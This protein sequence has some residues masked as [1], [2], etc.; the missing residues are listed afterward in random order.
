MKVMKKPLMQ[1]NLIENKWNLNY[2][3]ILPAQIQQKVLRKYWRRFS[4]LTNAL[5]VKHHAL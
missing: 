1:I 5:N 2:I 3:Q 4:L